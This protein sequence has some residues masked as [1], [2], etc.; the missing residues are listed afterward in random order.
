M[1]LF[2]VFCCFF[3]F[4]RCLKTF[5]NKSVLSFSLNCVFS[6][7]LIYLFLFLQKLKLQLLLLL[8]V[9]VFKFFL[10]LLWYLLINSLIFRRFSCSL[11][12]IVD[13]CS[14]S[15]CCFP[16]FLIRLASAYFSFAFS[17][18]FSSFS[19]YLTFK[20]IKNFFLF[21]SVFLFFFR[22]W[23]SGYPRFFFFFSLL[24]FKFL[25]CF[26]FFNCCLKILLNKSVFFFYLF[27]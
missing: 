20:F 12:H 14:Y 23:L 9:A 2:K 19:S 1:Q 24:F 11:F 3:F 10:S 4:S 18:R 8:S 25:C 5:F 27:S 21:F 15:S 6:C 26:F 22:P 13:P 17:C 7:S 16:V